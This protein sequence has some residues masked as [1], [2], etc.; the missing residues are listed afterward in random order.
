MILEAASTFPRMWSGPESFTTLLLL[1]AFDS[2]ILISEGRGDEGRVVAGVG[3]SEGCGRGM[4]PCVEVERECEESPY[5]EPEIEGSVGE[6]G[7][8]WSPNPGVGTGAE[9]PG[10]R[11]SLV[12]VGIYVIVVFFSLQLRRMRDS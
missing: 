12:S 1:T 8:G 6:Y 11:G 2:G 10:P 3:F 9:A 4:Y 5:W 7:G